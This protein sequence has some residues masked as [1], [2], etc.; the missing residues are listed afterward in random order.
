MAREDGR[1][2][3]KPCANMLY[4]RLIDTL[5]TLS[6]PGFQC[7][8]GEFVDQPWHAILRHFPY[9]IV[10]RIG[11]QTPSDPGTRQAML[12]IVPHDIATLDFVDAAIHPN[13]LKQIG[14]LRLL[15]TLR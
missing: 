7:Q 12:D 6:L 11:E 1:L 4:G 8:L 3:L 14:A 5:C 13:A 2:P 15:Q 10:R 9:G